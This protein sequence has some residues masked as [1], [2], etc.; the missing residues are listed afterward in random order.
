MQLPDCEFFFLV[1]EQQ[2]LSRKI[3]I[4]VEKP[5]LEYKAPGILTVDQTRELLNTAQEIDSGMLTYIALAVFAGVRPHELL[6]LDSS[7]LNWTE[8]YWK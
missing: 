1:C 3:N 4:P 7:N 2:L 6:R 5:K 8:S